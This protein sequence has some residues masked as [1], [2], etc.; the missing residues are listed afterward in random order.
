MDCKTKIKNLAISLAD[1]SEVKLPL[2]LFSILLTASSIM[3]LLIKP[4]VLEEKV[5]E[6]FFITTLYPTVFLYSSLVILLSMLMTTK[7]IQ[8]EKGDSHVE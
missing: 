1:F 5:V 7:N 8:S 4:I 6:L 3:F 2:V